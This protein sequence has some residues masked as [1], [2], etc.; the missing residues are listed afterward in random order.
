MAVKVYV[1][2][3]L[4]AGAGVL[5][6]AVDYVRRGDTLRVEAQTGVKAA[7]VPGT[8]SPKQTPGEAPKD[9][10]KDSNKA[11]PEAPHANA[12]Q[13][14]ATPG[15]TSP[16]SNAPGTRAPGVRRIEGLDPASLPTKIGLDQAWTLHEDAVQFID[17]RKP[18]EFVAGHIPGAVNIRAADIQSGGDTW[19][20]F[21]TSADPGAWYVVYCEG[22]DC[23][24]SEQIRAFLVQ[25]GFKN[26]LIFEQGFPGW[27]GAALPTEKP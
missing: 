6:A 14:S 10:P 23:L 15:T 5:L 20:T 16:D 3:G 12:G 21:Y 9:T 11:T 22:G 4:L 13:P 27:V 25:A 17:G 2:A 19:R 7:G 24:E 1:A 18:D 8:A 26:I